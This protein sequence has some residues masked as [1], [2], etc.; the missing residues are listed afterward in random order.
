MLSDSLCRCDRT[1]THWNFLAMVFVLIFLCCGSTFADDWTT[2]FDGKSLD[3]W[4]PTR[5]NT[6]FALDRWSHRWIQF[7]QDSVLAHGRRVR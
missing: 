6:Q 3:G 5:D 7:R 4:K 1:T 2:L